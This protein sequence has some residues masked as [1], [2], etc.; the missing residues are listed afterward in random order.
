MTF[1]PLLETQFISLT[2]SFVISTFLVLGVTGWVT[3]RLARKKRTERGE[4]A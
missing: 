1:F 3:S 2:V 4:A